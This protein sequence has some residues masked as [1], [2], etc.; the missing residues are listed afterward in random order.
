M[1]NTIMSNEASPDEIL[2]VL[3]PELRKEIFSKDYLGIRDIQM[4]LGCSYWDAAKII[5]QI[6]RKCDRLHVRGKLHTQDYLDYFDLP[7]ERY[8]TVYAETAEQTRT[9]A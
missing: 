9:H 1:N 8:V 7:P 3:T 2:P 4:L 5:R 6:K